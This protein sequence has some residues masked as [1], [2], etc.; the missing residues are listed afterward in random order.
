MKEE[1]KK[2]MKQMLH[3]SSMGF[4]MVLAIIIGLAIGIFLDRRLGTHPWFTIIFLVLGVVAGF[5]NIF[6]IF[7]KYGLGE[8]KSD[9]KGNR[10]KQ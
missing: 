10:K 2:L 8:G 1:N 4:S 6:H 9:E 7:F 5:R 3:L